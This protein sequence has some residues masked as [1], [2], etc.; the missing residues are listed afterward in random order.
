MGVATAGLVSYSAYMVTTYYT[1]G[2][3][4]KSGD[5]T[6]SLPIGVKVVKEH[7]LHSLHSLDTAK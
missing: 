3:T 4:G 7:T 1:L 5:Y 6:H 2:I